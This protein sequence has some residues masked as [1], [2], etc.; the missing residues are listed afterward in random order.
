MGHTSALHLRVLQAAHADLE[1]GDRLREPVLEQL[2][3]DIGGDP[4]DFIVAVDRRDRDTVEVA[5]ERRCR[6]RLVFANDGAGLGDEDARPL[7]EYLAVV[8]AVRRVLVVERLDRIVPFGTVV[9]IHEARGEPIGILCP[10]PP[11]GLL[12]VEIVVFFFWPVLL[13]LDAHAVRLVGRVP[14]FGLT[15]RGVFDARRLR[16]PLGRFTHWNLSVCL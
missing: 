14:K 10:T 5:E 16:T 11:V 4:L 12:G 2:L 1:P 8:L 13:R 7:A 3:H 6:C 9:G 15:R